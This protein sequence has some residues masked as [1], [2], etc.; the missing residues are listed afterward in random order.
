MSAHSTHENASSTEKPAATREAR[1]ARRAGGSGKG[2]LV[3][4]L[5]GMAGLDEQEAALAPDMFTIATRGLRGRSAPVDG[6]LAARVERSTGVGVGHARVH[7]GPV[8]R[9]AAKQLGKSGYCYGADIALGDGAGEQVLLHELAHVAQQVGN[10]TGAATGRPLAGDLEAQA[11]AVAQAA[12]SGG[13]VGI[14]TGVGP[15]LAFDGGGDASIVSPDFDAWMREHNDAILAKAANFELNVAS[16]V[17]SKKAQEKLKHKTP[18]PF[19][20]WSFSP[21]TVKSTVVPTEAYEEAKK[22]FVKGYKASGGLLDVKGSVALGT[23]KGGDAPKAKASFVTGKLGAGAVEIYLDSAKSRID[24]A[25]HAA[26]VKIESAL[27]SAALGT[28]PEVKTVLVKITAFM[29]F[30]FEYQAKSIG[31]FF[32]LTTAGALEI[33]WVKAA[34]DYLPRVRAELKAGRNGG[35]ALANAADALD[36]D[37]KIGRLDDRIAKLAKQM[38]ASPADAKLA[39]QLEE[40]KAKRAELGQARQEADLSRL[41]GRGDV[42]AEELGDAA[43]LDPTKVDAETRGLQL[44]QKLNHAEQALAK[45]ELEVG[46]APTG[47]DVAR[48][49]AAREAAAAQVHQAKVAK[50]QHD[51]MVL[52]EQTGSAGLPEGRRRKKAVAELEQKAAELEA[53]GGAPKADVPQPKAE[54]PQ[55]KA[56]VPQPKADAPQPK[57]DAP[58]PKA[59]APQPK[60]DAP[61]PKADAPKPSWQQELDARVP[62]HEMTSRKVHGG[63]STT[64]EVKGAHTSDTYLTYQMRGKGEE[65]RVMAVEVDAPLRADP[66]SGRTSRG[67]GGMLYRKA[68]T[69]AME[70][71]PNLARISGDLQDDNR[72]AYI[73]A[74]EA[75]ADHIDALK[76]TPAYKIRASLGFDRIDAASA[77]PPKTFPP[78]LI[79]LTTHKTREV[80]FGAR[81]PSRDLPP[82]GADVPA[83]GPASASAPTP[84][85][86]GATKQAGYLKR[87]GEIVARIDAARRKM[88]E[89]VSN[90]RKQNPKGRQARRT[91]NT[92]IQR[93]QERYRQ[94][95]APLN[96][97]LAALDKKA[98]QGGLER[99]KDAPTPHRL[100][101]QADGV[102]SSLA[103]A[104]VAVDRQVQEL[105]EGASKVDPK[106][107]QK[108]T[109]ANLRAKMPKGIPADVAEKALQAAEK[110][111]AEE[112]AGQADTLADKTKQLQKMAIKKARDRVAREGA[113]RIATDEGTRFFGLLAEQIDGVPLTVSKGAEEALKKPFKSAGRFLPVAGFALDVY[114]IYDDLDSMGRTFDAFAKGEADS[115]DIMFE[116]LH[117]ATDVAGFVPGIGDAVSILG[118][119]IYTFKDSV[120][121]G[122]GAV[123]DGVGNMAFNPGMIAN[124]LEN[125]FEDIFLLDGAERRE[126]YAKRHKTW[127]GSADYDKPREQKDGDLDKTPR[128]FDDQKSGEG[129]SAIPATRDSR[130]EPPA[131]LDDSAPSVALRQEY[132]PATK[133]LYLTFAKQEDV[134]KSMLDRGVSAV[135]RNTLDKRGRATRTS[136]LLKDHGPTTVEGKEVYRLLF[137]PLE[138]TARTEGGPATERGDNNRLLNLPS[139]QLETLIDWTTGLADPN[140]IDA[141]FVVSVNG[142]AGKA[143]LLKGLS[144]SP[145]GPGETTTC[146]MSLY[147]TDPK[148]TGVPQPTFD[149]KNFQQERFSYTRPSPD[150]KTPGEGAKQPGEGP[151]AGA[152]GG[153]TPEGAAKVPKKPS[154]DPAKTPGAAPEP[155][156][157]AESP[158]GTVLN[159]DNP[160]AIAPMIRW[161]G[162]DEREPEF[163]QSFSGRRYT[164]KRGSKVLFTGTLNVCWSEQ[165]KVAPGER[166][167]VAL[168]FTV[169]DGKSVDMKEVKA[170]FMRP[171]VMPTQLSSRIESTV[172]LKI[173]DAPGGGKAYDVA[174]RSFGHSFRA[175]GFGAWAVK[176]KLAGLSDDRAGNRRTFTFEVTEVNAAWPAAAK[177]DWVVGATF[178]QSEPLLDTVPLPVDQLIKLLKGGNALMKVQNNDGAKGTLTFG[179]GRVEATE[180]V[181]KVKGTILGIDPASLSPVPIHDPD[182]GWFDAKKGSEITATRVGGPIDAR[183]ALWKKMGVVLK[184]DGS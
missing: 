108:K 97:E 71:N 174:D 172:G 63:K 183:D 151:A 123:A 23:N 137:V 26:G 86:A 117:L 167:D 32:D 60:A 27:L 176:A 110:K 2:R 41:E 103:E 104:V 147:L 165:A 66:T 166:V 95:I 33:D 30:G 100:V 40:A 53:L 65:F 170:A 134:P 149:Q 119:V 5:R 57:A 138:S 162:K 80:D 116:V 68:L 69:E 1:P 102:G 96:Q 31:V 7:R 74:R 90:L 115:L 153:A 143:A 99:A 11:D 58:L 37:H 184:R 152:P 140:W 180:D 105:I 148:G 160:S 114:A 6:G 42:L 16:M 14:T 112:I 8:A 9:A 132:D 144:A 127:A 55:P 106:A 79:P 88:D 118:E 126:K 109:I 25:C 35:S 73:K 124:A 158:V 178:E 135:V 136:F 154:K 38:E 17:L 47:G 28:H 50:L 181:D 70:E 91:R 98:V 44:E 142:G 64:I 4:S 43:T 75:G 82:I 130:L 59:D 72:L 3:G 19:L 61:L 22:A 163:V 175:P 51:V 39:G 155:A 179:N 121:E 129:D 48:L 111:L 76:A 62:D 29:R 87:R 18:V 10:P 107:L 182:Q 161:V 67:V 13:F 139:A 157:K 78:D 177:N 128:A 164:V 49:K 146:S 173:V 93:L 46:K 120:R 171:R 145:V 81:M 20:Q 54:A 92:K 84:A 36:R 94:K 15:Q 122:M 125:L 169:S 150:A 12:R 52:K 131:K 45:A 77:K 101:K 113:A 56:D 156:K 159:L 168:G 133:L 34:K 85:P 24:D 141:P 89:A 21:L 83:P